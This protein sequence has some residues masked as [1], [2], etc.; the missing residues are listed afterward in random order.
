VASITAASASRRTEARLR[1]LVPA[2]RRA[3]AGGSAGVSGPTVFFF[4]IFLTVLQCNTWS[5]IVARMKPGLIFEI[6]EKADRARNSYIT[7]LEHETL[8]RSS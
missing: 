1:G 6:V 8:G 2:A 7:G 4:A 5:D 3:G